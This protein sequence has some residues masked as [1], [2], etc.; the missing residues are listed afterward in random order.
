MKFKTFRGLIIGVALVGGIG[1]WAASCAFCTKR[2][3]DD[4][5]ARAPQ[6]VP[7]AMPSPPTAV[8][9][10]TATPTVAASAPAGGSDRATLRAMDREVLA[11]IAGPVPGGKIKD[12][13]PGRPYK[14]SIYKDAGHAKA[15]RVKIDLDRNGKWDEKWTLEDD[16]K[17]K[18]KVA[19]RDDENY[20]LEFRLRGDT[21]AAKSAP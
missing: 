12:L 15:N 4:N 18:R 3:P 5:G 7:T 19:P 17:I 20:T 11:R 13:F 9:A 2:A 8:T 6:D 21:W 1:L 14:V 16:G 10:A